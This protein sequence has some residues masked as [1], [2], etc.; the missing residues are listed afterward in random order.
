MKKRFLAIALIILIG[1]ISKGA[2]PV[3]TEPSSPLACTSF[4]VYSGSPI[5]GMN[6]DYPE[7]PVRFTIQEFGDLQVFQMEFKDEGDYIPTVGMN[8]EGLFVSSQMLFPEMPASPSDTENPLSIWQLYQAGLYSHTSVTEVL[9]LVEEYQI[10]NSSLTLHGLFADPSGAAVVVEVIKD[11]E[12]LT[13]ITG[14][15]I[16]MT[17]FPVSSIRGQPI[18]EVEGVGADRYKIAVLVIQENI[19]N[20]QVDTGLRILEETALL[21]EFSTQASMVFDPINLL[22]YIA[23]DRDFNKVWLVSLKDNTIST[24]RGFTSQQTLPIDH[25]G[26]TEEVMAEMGLSLPADQI[27]FLDLLLPIALLSIL[28]LMIWSLRKFTRKTPMKG[29]GG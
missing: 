21:G 2:P 23:L 6:F 1:V 17:N 26:V 10:T 18:D 3:K 7:V 9:D 25:R 16:V 27:Q 15:Y 19:D 12:E 24:F 14:N 20:F 13:P 29:R 28:V 11:Q 5:Y 8:N 4:A 22:I